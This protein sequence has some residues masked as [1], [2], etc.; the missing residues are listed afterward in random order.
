MS[1]SPATGPIV[2][3]PK[4]YLDYFQD[5]VAFLE[6]NYAHIIGGPERTFLNDFQ[7]LSEDAQ[8]LF[9]RFSN[10]KGPCFRVNKLDY[11]EIK[12]IPAATYELLEGGFISEDLPE[13]YATFNLFL[14]KELITAYPELEPFR[15]EKKALLIERLLENESSVDEIAAKEPVVLVEKQEEFEYLKLLYFGEYKV[16]MTEFVIR[17]VGHVKLES[18]DENSFKPWCESRKEARAFF[19]IS[20]IKS[21]IRKALKLFPAAIIHDEL[22]EIPWELFQQFQQSEKALSKIAI[23]LGQQLEREKEPEL[24][25][26]YYQLTERH[27]S[28]ERQ[29][30]ILDGLGEKPAAEELA[31]KMATHHT[32]ASEKIFALDFLN[33]PKVR[34]NR[35]MT[36]RL[37]SS[38]SVDLLPMPGLKVEQLVINHFEASGFNAIHAENFLWRN[39]FGLLYWEEL[40]DQ[41]QDGF[42]HPLQRRSND[43]YQPEFFSKRE[44]AFTAKA[45]VL[46]SRKKIKSKI[47]QTHQDKY[48]IAGPMVYWYEDMLLPLHELVGKLLPRQIKGITWEMARNMKENAT[49]FPDLFIWNENEYFF[50]EIKSPNDHLSAQ[51]LFWLEIMQELKINADILR[52]NYNKP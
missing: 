50:Y 45:R 11:E 27:P 48:G 10:R 7:S 42:H 25:L 47:N 34:I 43:L 41:S 22:G 32:N 13:E 19:E 1:E 30:R 37:V 29:V 31:Q 39:L 21:T 40:F 2:L 15:Q 20:Q 24:A 3:P 5:L 35:S 18:L 49:G 44:A 17:D 16:P 9:L 23:E 8:C 14:K 28:R 33:R 6:S 4:Y 38:P 51:Q 52:V 12:D 36:A 26:K 46:N